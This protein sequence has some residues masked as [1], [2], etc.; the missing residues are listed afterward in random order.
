MR[1]LCSLMLLFHFVSPAKS[2]V[3]E[4]VLNNTTAIRS[5][6]FNDTAYDDLLPVANAIGDKRVVMLG[7]LF[8]GDGEAFRLKSRLVRFLHERMGFRVI[9][10]ESDFFSLYHGWEAYKK[11]EISFDSLLYLSIFPV[12]TQCEQMH[13][14]FRYIDQHQLRICGM[15]NRGLSG[16]GMR[17]LRRAVDSF[18]QQ[19]NIPFV[20]HPDYGY[21]LSAVGKSY[22]ILYGRNRPALDSMLTLLPIV[23]NQIPEDGFYSHV[24][25][26]LLLNY[27]L[28]LHYQ[29]SDEYKKKPKD[30]PLHDHQLAENLKWLV[31]DKFSDQKIIVWAHNAHVEKGAADRTYNSMGHL[32]TK[33]PRLAEQTYIIGLT[34]YE[35]SGALT[36]RDTKEAVTKP[37]RNSI[38]SWMHQKGHPYSFI[39]LGSFNRQDKGESF[40][41]K[42]YINTQKKLPWNRFYDGVIYVRE[43]KPCEKRAYTTR[44][45]Q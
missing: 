27:Q 41:M 15:D 26:G 32:F 25:K 3:K 16:Y 19:S 39:D 8:H 13:E 11:K 21:F 42:T 9:V 20:Q 44:G 34:C 14:L 40:Y 10:F 30:H 1:M 37:G 24:L 29:Y 23:I 12:W 45:V 36:I 2:Q 43:A 33:D 31:S 7:E 4:Y 18:L 5:A 17:Y 6:D 38:E 22:S 28:S 35:G